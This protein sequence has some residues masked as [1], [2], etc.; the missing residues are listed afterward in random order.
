[1]TTKTETF[2]PTKPA[3][4]WGLWHNMAWVGAMDC[5]GDPCL[6]YETKEEAERGAQYH[7]DNYDMPDVVV[8]RLF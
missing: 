7:R 1:M 2:P 8:A 4:M 3:E 6:W 5:A